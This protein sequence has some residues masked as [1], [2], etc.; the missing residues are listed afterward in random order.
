VLDYTFWPQ[1][2]GE[3]KRLV[4]TKSGGTDVVANFDFGA[5]DS[6]AV[7]IPL[8][9]KDGDKYYCN[10]LMTKYHDRAPVWLPF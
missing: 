9:M 8:Q 6:S 1:H 2:I 5:G 4:I 10:I 7:T 3:N